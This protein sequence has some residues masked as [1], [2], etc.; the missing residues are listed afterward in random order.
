MKNWQVA[1][2]LLAIIPPL[3]LYSS[4]TSTSPETA[5]QEWVKEFG[6]SFSNEE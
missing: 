1:L 4:E 6:H 3:Y 5:F 2:L